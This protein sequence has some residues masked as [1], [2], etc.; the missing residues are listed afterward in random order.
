VV[1][2]RED[3]A[4]RRLHVALPDG[5]VL[6]ADVD[7]E[8]ARGEPTLITGASGSG[9]ST[10]FRALAGIWPFGSG[11]VRWPAGTRVLFLPQRPY[12]P[13]GP[14]RAVIAYPA[15]P[16]AFP[17]QAVR[18]T[19]VECGLGHLLERL[20]ESQHWALIL[21]GGEQQRIA[22]A[23]ALLHRPDW[24]FL[25][26]ASS[27]LDEAAERHLYGLLRALPA[28]TIVSIGHRPGLSAFH[29]RLLA[30]ETDVGGMPRLVPRPPRLIHS[31]V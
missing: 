16:D 27:A 17:L 11:E 15:P 21:S 28:T 14:L 31:G 9:K 6:L 24:V 26:E 29:A 8:L 10:L 3:I 5:R 13:L 7:L 18:A 1:E 20:D 23:R 30:I 22:F 12:L 19:M 2:A 4:T 25:D